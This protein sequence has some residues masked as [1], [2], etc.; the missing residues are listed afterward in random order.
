[1]K[2]LLFAI[3]LMIGALTTAQAQYASLAIDQR[4]GQRYGWAVN[5]ETQASADKRALDECQ[6]SGGNCHVVLRFEGG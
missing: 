5:Y 2:K 6:K 4:A 3:I 1:M